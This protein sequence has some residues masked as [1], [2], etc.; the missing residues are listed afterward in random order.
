MVFH[1]DSN[2]NPF[3]TVPRTV[4]IWPLLC[5]EPDLVGDERAI[6]EALSTPS[7]EPVDLSKLTDAKL[8][9]K[10]DW[11]VERVRVA[12]DLLWQRI[13]RHQ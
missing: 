13:K 10:L 11:S 5:F 9:K 6:Y 8:A 12:T 1:C 4:E 2:G 7:H 3:Y